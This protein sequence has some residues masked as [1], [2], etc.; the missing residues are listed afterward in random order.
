MT[1]SNGHPVRLAGGR[2]ALD[3]LNTADWSDDGAIVHEKIKTQD[4]LDVWLDAVGLPQAERPRDIAELYAFRLDLRRAIVETQPV[5][6]A[7]SLS[8]VRAVEDDVAP[9]R[10]PLFA[11]AAMSASSILVDPRERGRIKM[12]PGPECGWLF[13]DETRNARRKWCLMETCGNRA[14]AARHYGKVREER[15]REG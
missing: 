7:G 5:V 12:C 4:D 13:I 11:L 2:L 9:D 15:S 6:V 10:Q 14:K 8:H 3:L 1:Y